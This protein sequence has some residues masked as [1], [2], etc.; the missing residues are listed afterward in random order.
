MKSEM[1]RYTEANR[2]AWNEVMPL[3]QRAAKEMWN[4]SFSQPGFVA[5]DEA[6]IESWQ[7][8]RN[9]RVSIFS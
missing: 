5:L 8:A 7:T 4:D 9:Q 6:E 1:K 2:E 3:H